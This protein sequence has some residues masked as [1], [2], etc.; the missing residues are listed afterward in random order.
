MVN[1][2]QPLLQMEHITK[3]FP[4]VLALDDVD[5]AVYPG[6]I[7][8]FL[9][10]NGAGKSTLIKILSGIHLKDSGTIR[11]NGQEISPHTPQEAQKLGISTIHQELAL[12]P[13]LSVAENIFLNRE[14]RRALG[15]VDF[16]RMNREAEALLH[17]LGAD[18]PGRKLVRDLNVAAQQMV[19]IAKAV[20]QSAQLILMDEPTSALSSKETA[21][22]FTLMQRLKERGVAV[23]FVS[24]RLDEVRQIVDRVIIMRDGRYVGAY[25]IEEVSEEQIIRL[26]VGRDVGLFPKE[27]AEVGEPVLEVRDLCG[28]NGVEHIDLTVRAGE[29]VGLSGLVGAGR[30]ELVRLIC[31][32]DKV[33]QGEVLING[34]TV[35]IKSPMQA[36]KH[37]IGWVPEDRKLHGLILEMDVKDNT[38]MAILQRISNVFGAIKNSEAKQ[39]TRDYV[40]ALSIATP[41]I[42][43]TVRNLSGGNQQKV[44]LAK[45]LSTKPKLLIMDEPTRGI[46]IGAKTEV[47]ALMSRLAKQGI[48]ILMISSELPEI[49]GMSDRVIVMC[50]GRITGEFTR[51]NLSQE[52]IM[53]CAT[54]FLTVDEGAPAAI[55]M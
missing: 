5:F 50:Q 17:D 16:R 25:P 30:T 36:V 34:R 7:V 13:Y 23:V 19:E 2:Q 42:N 14:P 24:H 26:M 41:D 15:M 31:G 49:I 46:D 38:T 40:A 43:Q 45:W 1:T 48:G 52:E 54:Q 47:H 28:D 33:T 53:T 44:V 55:E 9:G 11:F 51:G 6:E 29:I 18:I 39:V 10:E 22:L 20:S 35:N 21:A 32:V 8:G 27:E 37:G 3:R 4:G 12:I